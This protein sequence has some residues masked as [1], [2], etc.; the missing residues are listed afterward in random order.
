[1]AVGTSPAVAF[2][3]LKSGP[4]PLSAARAWGTLAFLTLLY[5]SSYIDRTILGLLVTPIRAALHLS[6]T[7]FSLIA[8]LA[9]VTVYAIGGVAIGVLVDRW[10]VFGNDLSVCRS[11]ALVGV[12]TVP[13]AMLLLLA[14]R[15]PII[16]GM[17]ETMR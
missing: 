5:T 14:A 12:L 16:A 11:I 7:G 8:G 10:S 9:F 4:P 6:D 13:T 3:A 2:G 15:R 1:M 17:A